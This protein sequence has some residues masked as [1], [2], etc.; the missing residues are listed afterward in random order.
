MAFP[1]VS[2]KGT[3]HVDSGVE[4]SHVI[5]LPDGIVSGD[6]LM[7]FFSC[8]GT[9]DHTWPTS[10]AWT[11]LAKI[12]NGTAT[13]S[14]S[15]GYRIA[16]GSDGTSM[17]IVS[18]S[19]KAV[20][21]S[22]RITDWHGTTI[23]EYATASGDTTTPD[24][25]NLT[26]SW[27]ADDTLWISWYGINGNG[28]GTT[29]PTNYADNREYAETSA[30]ASVSGAMCSRNLNATSDNPSTF[31]SS[32]A[33]GWGAAIVAIRPAAPAV[34]QPAMIRTQGVPTAPGRGD[35]PGKWN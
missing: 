29:Y 17:T 6:L 34:G 4:T 28:A 11:R 7:V 26:P 33:S 2:T 15:F 3:T 8:D 13:A 22:W 16:N 32:G 14:I 12:N 9:G 10:P 5:D 35:R 20:A 24:P 23:P 25:P 19:E 21:F 31:Q 1:V 30:G 27:G 18:D